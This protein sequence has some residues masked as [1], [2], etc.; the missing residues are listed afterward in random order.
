MTKLSQNNWTH[1]PAA[2]DFDAAVNYL[3]LLLPEDTV[4]RALQRLRH[5][6]MVVRR[7]EDLLRASGLSELPSD[8]PTVA[9]QLKALKHGKL[10]SPVL[11]LRGDLHAG[12]DM[13]IA[14]GYHRVCA[15]YTLDEGADIPCRLAELPRPEETL[16][17]AVVATSRGADG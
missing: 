14:D 15:S 17:A 4:Q 2:E 5:G 13:V 9:K 11:C 6:P 7:A 8:N 1:T 16:A 10:F 3:S 12:A